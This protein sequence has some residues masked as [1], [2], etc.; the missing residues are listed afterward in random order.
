MWCHFLQT[1]GNK[2]EP[3]IKMK[4]KRTIYT[5][6]MVKNARYNVANYEWGKKLLKEVTEKE[7]YFKIF[8]NELD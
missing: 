6:E 4:T 1:K 5:E 2:M 3:D 7:T 8:T